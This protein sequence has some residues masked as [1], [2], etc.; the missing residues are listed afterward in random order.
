MPALHEEEL[1]SQDAAAPQ[2]EFLGHPV[3]LY[4]L[5]FT[6]MWERFSYYGMRAILMLYMVQYLAWSDGKAGGLYGDYTGLVYITPLFGGFLADRY[7]GLRRAIVIGAFTMALGQGFLAFNAYPTTAGGVAAGGGL[8]VATLYLGLLL[9]IAGNG[10]FKP[11][12]STLVGQLYGPEDPRRDAAFTIF[13]M[14]INIG[15]FLAPLICGTL[16]QH[17]SFGWHWGFGAACVGMVLGGVIFLWGARFLGEKG[18]KPV[19]GDHHAGGAVLEPIST[20]EKARLAV[21]GVIGAAV[22]LAFALYTFNETGSIVDAV[23]AVIW[24][25][26]VFIVIGMYLFMH[27]RCTKEEMAKVS[28]IFVLGIF[29]MI[30]WAAYEQAGSSLTLFADRSTRLEIFGFPFVAS[31]FQALPALLVILFAPIFS[32][33]WTWLSLKGKDP[34]TPVKMALGLL[35]NGAGFLMMVQAALLAADGGR[36][37]PL[38]LSACYLLQVMGELCLSPIGLSMVTRLA[39]ARYGAMLMGVWFL[40]NAFAGKLAGFAGSLY[41]T[42]ETTTLFA[43]TAAILLVFGGLLVVAVPWLKRKMA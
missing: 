28:V 21:V 5:F 38:W 40:A 29:V 20:K 30:F 43:G 1:L 41:G 16:A 39:P 3:G 17:E 24:P 36:V 2:R 14:G 31:N 15:A 25:A 42:L 23:R 18:I 33:V 32:A 19:P 26:T 34:S 12:I 6:E 7:L 8:G 9:L 22:A 11:N 37:S 13:Y 35:F 4:V 27:G 10:F